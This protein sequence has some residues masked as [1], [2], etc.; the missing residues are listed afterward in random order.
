[1]PTPA[2]VYMPQRYLEQDVRA[3]SARLLVSD[4]QT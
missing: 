2:A 3:S 1:M 4:S